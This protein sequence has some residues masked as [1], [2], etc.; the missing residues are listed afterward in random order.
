MPQFLGFA[1]VY[2][3]GLYVPGLSGYGVDDRCLELIRTSFMVCYLTLAAVLHTPATVLYLVACPKLTWFLMH[4]SFLLSACFL[5]RV[6]LSATPRPVPPITTGGLL[7]S[8]KGI[9]FW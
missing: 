1:P 9:P 2:L 8:T 6:R 3:P 7:G 5:H 4:T